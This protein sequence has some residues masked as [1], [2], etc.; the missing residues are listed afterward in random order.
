MSLPTKA[1]IKTTCSLFR[2]LKPQQSIDLPS[3]ATGAGSPCGA[4]KFLRRKC[5][6]DCIFAPYF[7]SDQSPAQF[8]AIHKVFGASNVSK[9]LAQVPVHDRCE[10]VATIAYEAQARIKD[11]VYGSVL[12]AQVMQVKAQLAYRAALSR[13]LEDQQ[14]QDNFSVFLQSDSEYGADGVLL[15]Q[16]MGCREDVSTQEFSR[17]RTPHHEFGELQAMAQR[18]MRS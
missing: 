13:V 1:P 15:M 9:L 4:C 18:M 5:T 11:P 14:C 12:Q 8:A 6:S 17:K 3:M 7:G 16:Q 10:A 2:S